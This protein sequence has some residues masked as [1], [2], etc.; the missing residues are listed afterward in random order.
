VSRPR[1]FDERTV[2]EAIRGAFWDR[3]YA[4]TSVDDLA[5]ATGLG[6]GSLYGAFG[7]KHEMFVSALR[8]YCAAALAHAHQQLA[9]K[10]AGAATRLRAYVRGMVAIIASSKRGCLLAKAVAELAGEAEDVDQI[11]TDFY[12]RYE[13]ILARAIRAAQKSGEIPRDGNAQR[14]ASM[15]VAVLRGLESMGKGG[16]PTKTLRGVA[17][18]A[19]ASL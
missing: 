12:K 14:Q 1:E 8:G 4:A 2:L 15:L 18:S 9:G 10:D 11:V 6:K 3:G 13:D 17:D 19:L 16:V 7:S 5:K